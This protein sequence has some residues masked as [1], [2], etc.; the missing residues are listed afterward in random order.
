MPTPENRESVVDATGLF[1]LQLIQTPHCYHRRPWRRQSRFSERYIQRRRLRILG[2]LR[3][4][5]QLNPKQRTCV[6]LHFRYGVHSLQGKPIKLLED[7]I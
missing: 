5:V 4:I 1:A 6:P 7:L 3:F 2:E